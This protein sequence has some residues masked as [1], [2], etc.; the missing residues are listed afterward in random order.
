MY[1]E[2]KIIDVT[3]DGSG[4]AT[5]YSEAATGRVLCIRYVKDATTPFA[6]TADF[7]FTSEASGIAILTVA[8]VTAST[9]WYPVAPCVTVA[10][11]AAS[12]LSEQAPVIAAERI[13]LVTAQGGASKVGRFHVVIG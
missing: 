6:D 9:T 3:T 7:T 2:R 11:G 10:A 1:A 13:K 12:T 5:T 8:N 4:D